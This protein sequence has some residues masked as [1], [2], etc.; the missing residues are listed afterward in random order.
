[1]RG[2]PFLAENP[3]QGAIPSAGY[4]LTTFWNN[5]ELETLS[6]TWRD[7][8]ASAGSGQPCSL[9]ADGDGRCARMT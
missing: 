7:S 4:F 1:M 5:D 9:L 2:L 8:T 3:R 6:P